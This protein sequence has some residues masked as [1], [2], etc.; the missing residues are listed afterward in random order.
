MYLEDMN[1]IMLEILF[2]LIYNVYEYNVFLK[3]DFFIYLLISLFWLMFELKLEKNMWL[4][5]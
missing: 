3:F 2:F 5:F 4:V 1:F